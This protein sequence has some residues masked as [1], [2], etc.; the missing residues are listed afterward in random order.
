VIA[1][2]LCEQ[3]RDDHLGE[4]EECN[5]LLDTATTKHPAPDQLVGEVHLTATAKQ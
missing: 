2:F 4:A 3:T 1:E 5:L